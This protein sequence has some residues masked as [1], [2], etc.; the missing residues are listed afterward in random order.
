MFYFRKTR[1][2][3]FENSFLYISS[4]IGHISRYA[5]VSLILSVYSVSLNENLL[6]QD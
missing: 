3:S 5:C 1:E 2:L 4:R 6:F